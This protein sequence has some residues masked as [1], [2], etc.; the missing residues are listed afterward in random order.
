MRKPVNFLG[1]IQAL[2]HI[3][4]QQGVA[5]DDMVYVMTRMARQMEEVSVYSTNTMST[6]KRTAQLPE[7]L[8]IHSRECYAAGVLHRMLAGG[9]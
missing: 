2:G 3:R 6:I 8:K 4:E 5:S 1:I 9:H 7:S